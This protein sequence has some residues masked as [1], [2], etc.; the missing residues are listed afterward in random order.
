MTFVISSGAEGAAPFLAYEEAFPRCADA[1]LDCEQDLR[2]CDREQMCA[3]MRSDREQDLPRA[4][5]SHSKFEF[6]LKFNKGIFRF[7]A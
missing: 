4:L 6:L 3:K 2:T 7:S 5:S 1:V